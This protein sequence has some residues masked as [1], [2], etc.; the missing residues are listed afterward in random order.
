MKWK[1]II[2]QVEDGKALQTFRKKVPYKHWNHFH[3]FI[4]KGVLMKDTDYELPLGVLG[5]IAHQLFVKENSKVFS[6]SDTGF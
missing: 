1:T 4:P 5:K 6:I 2:S 3:E